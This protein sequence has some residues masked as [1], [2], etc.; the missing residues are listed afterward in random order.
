MEGAL[1]KEVSTLWAKRTD[2]VRVKF[3]V[4]MGNRT[5]PHEVLATPDEEFEVGDII[6][7]GKARAIVHHIRTRHRTMREGRIRADEIVRMYGRVV[8]ERTSR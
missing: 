7:L 5:V 1:A 8:R 6:D 3:S 2:R 4:N